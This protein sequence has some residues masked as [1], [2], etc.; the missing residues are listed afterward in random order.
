MSKPTH[1]LRR[2]PPRAEAHPAETAADRSGGFH[3][4]MNSSATKRVLP[5]YATP[6]PI[7]VML[8]FNMFAACSGAPSNRLASPA[9]LVAGVLAPTFS[10]RRPH[11]TVLPLAT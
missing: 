3:C 7:D 11:L 5:E 9:L 4:A 2:S 1:S 6:T 8:V 10:S